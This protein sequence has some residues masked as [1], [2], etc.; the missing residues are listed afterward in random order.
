MA[1]D[2]NEEDIISRF[3]WFEPGQFALD[4]TESAIGFRG[5][6]QSEFIF[7]R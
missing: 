5:S 3:S 7:Y 6:I 1:Q 2:M 4:Q